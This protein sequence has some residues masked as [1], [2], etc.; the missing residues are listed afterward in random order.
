MKR[1]EA[2]AFV[3]AEIERIELLNQG[4]ELRPW[5]RDACPAAKEHWRRVQQRIALESNG[6]RGP[7]HCLDEFN[8]EPEL[9]DRQ[10][11]ALHATTFPKRTG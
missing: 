8:L 10:L 2:L 3:E 7:T 6:R 9:T 11:S 4:K 1:A 5:E